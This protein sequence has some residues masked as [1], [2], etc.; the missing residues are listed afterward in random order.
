MNDRKKILVVSRMTK[1]CQETI[2]YAISA[3][4]Q[5]DAEL[6]IIHLPHDIHNLDEKNLP[7]GCSAKDLADA[8]LSVK[9][10]LEWIIRNVRIGGMHVKELIMAGD[11]VEEIMKT[12]AAEKIDILVLRPHEE[13]QP[14]NYLFGS[15]TEEL[16]RRKPCQINF[17]KKKTHRAIQKKT[18]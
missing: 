15:I 12:I 6:F 18:R 9:A 17:V 10:S 14:E 1:Y 5:Y 2:K 13:S 7:S 11:P 16:V 8:S 3:A 4:G